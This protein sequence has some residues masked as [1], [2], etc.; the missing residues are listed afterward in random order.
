MR[1]SASPLEVGPAY[2]FPED[3]CDVAQAL[4]LRRGAVKRVELDFE[5][6][7]ELDVVRHAIRERWQAYVD[8]KIIKLTV[9]G[10]SA[11]VTSNEAVED[12]SSAKESEIAQI[13]G[14]TQRVEDL[15]LA[16]IDQ[17]YFTE[18]ATAEPVRWQIGDDAS[19]AGRRTGPTT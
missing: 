8:A 11:S 17:P 10:V 9:M 14:K 16:T 1:E 7:H 15:E 2:V 19:V 13:F 5:S 3:V 12:Q 4:R 18:K 6:R